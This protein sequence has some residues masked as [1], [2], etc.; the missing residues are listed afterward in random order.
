VQDAYNLRIRV[1]PADYIA[2]L[3]PWEGIS[4]FVTQSSIVPTISMKRQDRS[5]HS[6]QCTGQRLR[7]SEGN[8]APVVICR[9]D[10]CRLSLFKESLNPT[11]RYMKQR[12]IFETLFKVV[13]GCSTGW[14]SHTMTTQ[15]ETSWSLQSLTDRYCCLLPRPALT[16]RDR[17]WF[18]LS[19]FA[20]CYW[21]RTP[22][23]L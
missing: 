5:I 8:A 23:D 2:T 12:R 11:C 6:A 4:L 19:Q 3:P 10:R 15:Y 20:A 16:K 17:V 7:L 14:I 1:T 18:F 21:R 13:V 22:S 9:G